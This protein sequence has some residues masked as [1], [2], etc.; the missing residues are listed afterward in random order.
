MLKDKVEETEKAR[1]S[2]DLDAALTSMK[3]MGKE[4][5]P[6]KICPE[7]SA[8]ARAAR[9]RSLTAQQEWACSGITALFSQWLGT[10]QGKAQ[11]CCGLPWHQRDGPGTVCQ[12]G[13]HSKRSEWCL[14]TAANSTV[15]NRYYR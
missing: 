7:G 6:R 15:R 14:F 3:E 8:C 12:L 11:S 10:A 5:I 2:S 1:G 9:W 13:S 4:G